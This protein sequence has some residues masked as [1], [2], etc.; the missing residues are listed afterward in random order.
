MKEMK[1]T[2]KYVRN[3]IDD[4]VR[5]ISRKIDTDRKNVYDFLLE[6]MKAWS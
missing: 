1:A 6:T 2:D 3:D 4:I 5:M